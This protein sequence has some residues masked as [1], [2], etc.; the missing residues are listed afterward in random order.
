MALTSPRP[1]SVWWRG[2]VRLQ[3][4]RV[5]PI[6][7]RPYN[8][9]EYYF[10]AGLRNPK[11]EGTRSLYQLFLKV[12][13]ADKEAVLKFCE[14]YGVLGEFQF[15]G[16]KDHEVRMGE[17]LTGQY[18]RES[19]N[20][21]AR[22]HAKLQRPRLGKQLAGLPPQPIAL[23]RPMT[24]RQFEI[25][26]Q[27]LQKTIEWLEEATGGLDLKTR[28]EDQKRVLWRFREKFYMLRPYVEW[29]S[30][31][32]GWATGW[33]AGSLESLLYLMLLY[34]CQ[35]QGRIEVCPNCKTVFM[36]DRPKMRY[37]SDRCGV[38]FRVKKHR[39]LKHSKGKPQKET[40]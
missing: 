33:D 28:Q 32:D 13:A 2:E 26:Q 3:K 37:C 27:Q 34:D 25:A 11:D 8:P 36:A 10:P 9:F 15:K 18:K 24:I 30:T 7:R 21:F 4:E 1:V 29:D 20:A 19:S 31:Q 22:L 23:V 17:V 12:N 5:V 40:R 14:E 6:E 16:W 39:R 35:G 38:N